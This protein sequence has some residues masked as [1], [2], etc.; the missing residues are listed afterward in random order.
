MSWLSIGYSLWQNAFSLLQ[1]VIMID[2]F[3]FA[4]RLS[5][6]SLAGTGFFSYLYLEHSTVLSLIN[7]KCLLNLI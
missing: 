7:N 2:F 4:I 3:V 1:G 5:F 6:L